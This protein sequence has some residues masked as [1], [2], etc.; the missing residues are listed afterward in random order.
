VSL[1]SEAVGLLQELIRA[2]TVNPPGNETRAVEILERY[3]AASGVES[4]R[5]ARD[6]QRAN[7]V[8]RLRGGDGPTVLLLAHTD[9]VLADAA[10]WRHDPW[11]GALVDGEVWGRGALDMKGQVAASA[12][13]FASLAREGFRPPGDLV[14]ALTADE[15]A[16]DGFGLEWLCEEH[17]DL[18]RCDY[19]LN[20]G[21]G[22]RIVLGGA[23][24]YVI[25][26]AEKAT[27]PFALRVRG[28]AG[29]ASIPALADNALVRAAGLIEA[30]GGYRAPREL[31]PEVR[32]F[33]QLVA[34]TLPPADDAAELARRVAPE[35]A[36]LLEPLL[37]PT[38]SPTMIQ[39]SGKRNVIPGLVELEVDCRLLPE[40]QP[41]DV[42]PLIRAAL[43][44]GNWDLV[45]L[46]PAKG[47]TR[48]AAEGPLWDAIARFLDGIEP[49]AR[50]L[51]VCNTGFTDSHWL[52]AA[53]GTVAYGFF[54]MRDMDI[55]T[56]AKLIHSA[57]ER[58]PASDL[59]LAVDGLRAAVQS[60]TA[61][62]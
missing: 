15:E 4:T 60:L 28:R 45:W 55:E 62:A 59:G 39:G 6:P 11:S 35:F 34:G 27:A 46:E 50:P 17:P 36:P 54:P 24:Y 40:Q 41:A 23:P 20:E 1:Q 57:D 31:I 43:P 38:F 8:A 42:E 29:H 13:A 44:A 25:G 22:E 2:N 51:P 33:F 37:S 47:G 10:E 3:L 49:G 32:T 16:G 18:V 48:S 53:F 9:T 30:I 52:R 56:T 58:I 14:L 7:L 61:A 21:G 26:T 5:V 12:V 19:A